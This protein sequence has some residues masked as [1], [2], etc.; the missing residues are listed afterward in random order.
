MRR[1]QQPINKNTQ[2]V[3]INRKPPYHTVC[4][5]VLVCD[6]KAD[7]YEDPYKGLYQIIMVWTNETITICHVSVKYCIKMLRIKP[8]NE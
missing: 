6:Q 1:K 3:N 7:K 8:Y 4:E 5:K 2:N